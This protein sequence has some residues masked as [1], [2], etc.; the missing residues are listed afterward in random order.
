MFF[1]Q[2]NMTLVLKLGNVCTY[3][4]KVGQQ[5]HDISHVSEDEQA[6]DSR[7]QCAG[8]PHHGASF[9]RGARVVGKLRRGNTH[10]LSCERKGRKNVN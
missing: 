8:S 2:K 3:N 1:L 9:H 5:P 4:F 10:R 7:E 6:G